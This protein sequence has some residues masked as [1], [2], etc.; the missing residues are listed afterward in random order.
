M[1]NKRECEEN[2]VLT[3]RETISEIQIIVGKIRKNEK[4]SCN[5]RKRVLYYSR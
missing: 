2:F 4:N 5:T 3:S 1:Y